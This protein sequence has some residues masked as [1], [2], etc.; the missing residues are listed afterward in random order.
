MVAPKPVPYSNSPIPPELV[1]LHSVHKTPWQ[2]SPA[3][4]DRIQKLVDS[5]V[6]K[7]DDFGNAK[8]SE[9]MKV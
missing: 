8:E 9:L 4:S 1:A 5:Y 3:L 7:I 2:L 6:A